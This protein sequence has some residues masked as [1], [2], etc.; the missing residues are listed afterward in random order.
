MYSL[1]EV[2]ELI[3]EEKALLI[4]FSAKSCSVCKTL[5]PKVWE[6][7]T[8]TFP[9]MRSIYVDTER[10]PLIAGQH[11]VFSIPTILLFF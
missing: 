7:I 8:G 5:R 6:M 1:Q 10:S 9:K 4:Y 11:R 2:E 3:R